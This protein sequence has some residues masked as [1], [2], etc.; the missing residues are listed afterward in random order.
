MITAVSA[1]IASW[2]LYLLTN[3]PKEMQGI[4]SQIEQLQPSQKKEQ[5]NLD[6]DNPLQAIELKTAAD[7]DK[8]REQAGENVKT[9][10]FAKMV[11]EVDEWLFVPEAEEQAVKKIEEMTQEL[12]ERI[13]GEVTSLLKTARESQNGKTSAEKIGIMKLVSRNWLVTPLK[14]MRQKGNTQESLD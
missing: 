13:N 7:I 11:A 9:I 4:R 6:D 2:S 5:N 12:R 14:L 10:D 3:I 8:R 1:A